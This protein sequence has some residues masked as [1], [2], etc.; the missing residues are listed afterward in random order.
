MNLIGCTF[1]S[2]E[3]NDK[4]GTTYTPFHCEG[5]SEVR[6]KSH[7][8]SR[9]VIYE[10]VFET[11][12]EHPDYIVQAVSFDK[13]ALYLKQPGLSPHYDIV[14]DTQYRDRVVL[15]AKQ[16]LNRAFTVRVMG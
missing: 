3:I 11:P 5:V 15:K 14:V 9:E 6:T 7:I 1:F 10:V 13:D 8:Q 4:P 12:F 2:G 16:G